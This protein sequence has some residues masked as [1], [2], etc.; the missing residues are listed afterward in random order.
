VTGAR[1]AGLRDLPV[2]A[3]IYRE[4]MQRVGASPGYLFEDSYFSALSEM[5]GEALQLFVVR[6]PDGT[7]VSAGLFTLCDG[8]LQYHLGGTRT[9]ALK[10][11]PMTLLLDTARLWA[12]EQQA[13]VFHLGGGVGAQ[14][15]SLFQF[16]AGF[17]GR[18][19]EFFT[20][21]WILEP[22]EYQA[23]CAVRQR[24][25]ESR[26]VVAPASD[27][28][29]AYRAPA[30]RRESRPFVNPPA[31]PKADRSLFVHHG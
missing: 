15:D 7:P 16:K 20:W 17:S 25:D 10:L 23:M 4:T 2:F 8:I 29:P 19:H 6:L 18:R 13:R 14:A 3:A 31:I 5:L 21:R 11:S 9:A 22:D 24:A 12:H 26:G 27:F 28:F 30:Q 1:D